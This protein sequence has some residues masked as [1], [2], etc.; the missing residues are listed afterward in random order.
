MIVKDDWL[1]VGAHDGIAVAC[2]DVVAIYIMR[3]F[4]QSGEGG[5]LYECSMMISIKKL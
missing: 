2:F 4:K 3:C 1:T 5:R